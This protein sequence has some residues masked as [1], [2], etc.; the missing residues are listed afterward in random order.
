M[1]LKG[2]GKC[3]LMMLLS[4]AF[5]FSVTASAQGSDDGTLFVT[6]KDGKRYIG[7]EKSSFCTN[8]IA[9]NGDG[10]AFYRYHIDLTG[11]NVTDITDLV[12]LHKALRSGESGLDLNFDNNLNNNDL[13][14]LRIVLISGADT[15]IN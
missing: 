2:I 9:A 1:E 5:V 15:E 8:Y 14:V 10:D 4:M 12:S 11:D 6:T 3:L 13:A 7:T